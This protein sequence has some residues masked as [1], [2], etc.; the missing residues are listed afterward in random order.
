MIVYLLLFFTHGLFYFLFTSLKKFSTHERG[1]SGH[2][3]TESRTSTQSGAHI[4]FTY[5]T[6]RARL[7]GGG[8]SWEELDTPRPIRVDITEYEDGVMIFS[9]TSLRGQSI[10]SPFTIS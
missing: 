9:T 7:L 4:T 6:Q 1:L 8:S 10:C 2:L 3:V 5:R